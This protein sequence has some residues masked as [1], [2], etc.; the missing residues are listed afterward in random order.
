MKMWEFRRPGENMSKKEPWF[1]E[2]NIIKLLTEIINLW[3]IQTTIQTT[4]PV[5][6]TITITQKMSQSV[7]LS[8]RAT[9]QASPKSTQPFDYPQ[10]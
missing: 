1:R 10:T 6:N 5:N 3:T 2:L 9:T 4:I 8:T 7:D